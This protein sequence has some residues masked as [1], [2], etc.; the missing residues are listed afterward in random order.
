MEQRSEKTDRLGSKRDVGEGSYLQ[1][2]TSERIISQ[3]N[4]SRREKGWAQQASNQSRKPQ[5]ICALPGFQNK[6]FALSKIVI[7]EWRPHVKNRFKRYIFQCAAKQGVLKISKISMGRK[8]VRVPLPLF[9]TRPST[10]SF[11]HVIKGSNVSAKAFDDSGNNIPGRSINFQ[12]YYGAFPSTRLCN[13]SATASRICDKFQEVC[14]RINSGNRFSGYDCELNENDIVF[15]SG[16]GSENKESVSGGVQES[17]T[18]INSF[19]MNINFH[20][21]SYSRSKSLV[22]VSSTTTNS[23]TK[24][25]CILHGHSA[26]ECYGQRGTC[27]VDKKFSINQW[28]GHYSVPIIDANADRWFQGRLGCSVS[29]DKNWGALVKEGTGVSYKSLR[30]FSNKICTSNLQQ[31]DEFQIITYPSRQPNCFELPIKNGKDKDSGTSQSFEG[32]LGVSSQTSD[33]DCCKVLPSLP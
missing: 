15:T 29:R 27:M 30:T 22:S 32:D 4:I 16:K 2:F 25:E 26:I 31:N 24:V 20:Y 17:L 6:G 3:S 19:V 9:W 28:S 21:S 10:K 1:S 5:Q 11:Y 18:R 7:T 33:H 14:F 13:I 8:L 23:N 12:K